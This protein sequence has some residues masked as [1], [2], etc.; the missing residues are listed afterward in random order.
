MICPDPASDGG[1]GGIDTKV[2]VK[3][4]TQVSPIL[5]HLTKQD[6]IDVLT[7]ADIYL[8]TTSVEVIDGCLDYL[9]GRGLTIALPVPPVSA[10]SKRRLFEYCHFAHIF[11]IGPLMRAVMHALCTTIHRHPEDWMDIEAIKELLEQ[12]TFEGNPARRY[13]AWTPAS[14]IIPWLI[15]KNGLPCTEA[16]IKHACEVS[17]VGLKGLWLG[18]KK[19]QQLRRSKEVVARLTQAMQAKEAE[20]ARQAERANQASKS[21]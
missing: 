16:D 17:W 2:S 14:G 8:T 7:N 11:G 18:D 1:K 6:G 3:V 20:K 4:I 15:G 19:V 13:F 12:K 10:D 21:K 9:E 5:M